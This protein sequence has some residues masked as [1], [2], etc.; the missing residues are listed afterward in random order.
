MVR[1]YAPTVLV[2]D[3]FY[4]A[5]VGFIAQAVKKN[6]FFSGTSQRGGALAISCSTL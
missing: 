1:K 4:N 2:K 6:A 3:R 5:A